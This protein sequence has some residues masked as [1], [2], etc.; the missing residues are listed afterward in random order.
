[1][2]PLIRLKVVHE[3]GWPHCPL[4]IDCWSITVVC[5]VRLLTEGNC[6]GCIAPYEYQ[7]LCHRK[8]FMNIY[9]S[10]LLIKN[11]LMVQHHTDLFPRTVT[12][13]WLVS[14]TPCNCIFNM[15]NYSVAKE[16]IRRSRRQH[17]YIQN[18]KRQHISF[19]KRSI[20]YFWSNA[21]L[22]DFQLNCSPVFLYWLTM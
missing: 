4:L 15:S 2:F 12:Q 8:G 7:C 1:M 13:N 11:G 22:F 14:G 3:T 10:L 18:R 21:V 9:L 20:F 5:K 16:S 19:P 6:S 17:K